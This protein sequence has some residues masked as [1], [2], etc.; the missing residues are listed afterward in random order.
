VVALR[1]LLKNENEENYELFN[2][3]TGKGRSVMQ[4]IETFEKVNDVKVNYT[5]GPRREGDVVQVWADTRKANDILGWKAK[6]DLEEMLRSAWEWQK[7]R[8]G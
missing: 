5:I 4:C 8:K 1:R 3:G 7:N 2:L 6:L